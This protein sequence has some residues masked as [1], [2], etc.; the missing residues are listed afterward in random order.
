MNEGK[1]FIIFH[2]QGD[3]YALPLDKVAVVVEPPPI[4][5]IP[6]SPECFIGGINFHGG[7]VALFDLA[8]LIGTDVATT[9]GKVIVFD[10]RFG[11]LAL[12]V[13]SVEAIFNEEVILE[14]DVADSELLE[15]VLVMADGSV[16]L[17]DVELIVEKLEELIGSIGTSVD[18]PEN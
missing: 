17:L 16:R 1:R 14:E 11:N 15:K 18:Q 10:R 9:W 12:M 5:P 13:E 2:I 8:L 6:R 4:Y 3:R 7:I